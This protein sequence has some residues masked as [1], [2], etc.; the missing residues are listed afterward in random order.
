[1]RVPSF[2]KTYQLSTINNINKKKQLHQ[3]GLSLH[4]RI[5]FLKKIALF[6][7]IPL[8]WHR[9][10]STDCHHGPP[11]A[12]FECGLHQ[13]HSWNT[14]AAFFSHQRWVVFFFFFGTTVSTLAV[15]L[16][17]CWRAAPSLQRTDASSGPR[18]WRYSEWRATRSSSP[19]QCWRERC[20]CAR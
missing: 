5:F 15:R 8:T 19:S 9:W 13:L 10:I 6:V 18:R 7:G 17:K 2:A 20:S 1:M 14:S 16:R 11:A 4:W 12:G 3:I